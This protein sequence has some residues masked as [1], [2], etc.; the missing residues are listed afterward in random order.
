[1]KKVVLIS[2]PFTLYAGIKGH[3]GLSAPLNLGY[4]TSYVMTK[5]D[6]FDVE[7]YDAEALAHPYEM[8]IQRLKEMKP[9]V[10]GFTTTTPSMDIIFKLTRM[11]HEELPGVKTILGGPHSTALPQETLSE[12]SVDFVVIGEGEQTFLELLTA[13]DDGATDFTKIDGVA[14]ID[15]S[16]QYV[17]NAPRQLIADIETIPWP[18]RERMPMHL[19][20]SPPT[21][22]LG[23][24]NVVT[25]LSS[26]GCP[27]TCNY[28]IS[29]VMW[30]RGSVRYA[31][32]ESVLAEMQ[33]CIDHYNARE[34]NFHDDLFMAKKQ[35]L[36]DICEGIIERRK[37]DPRWDIG[38]VV[39]SRIELIDEP[40]VKLMKEAG[41][42]K[43]AFGIESGSRRMLQKMNKSLRMEKVSVAF[44]ICR[45]YHIKTGASFM[46]GYLEETEESIHETI[47]LMKQLTPDTVA[48]FQAS[49]YPGTEF[50]AEAKA[51]GYIRKDMRWEDFALVT[52]SRAVVDLPNLSADQ[53]RYWVKRAYREFYI[54]PKYVWSQM[55]QIRT[56]GDIVNLARGMG[57]LFRVSQAK[58][59]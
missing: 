40:R 17:R 3:G 9:M 35:R 22:S 59:Y 58:Q 48:I 52:N 13:I 7:I 5:S 46:I 53:I 50:Y 14:Y 15:A 27:F 6:R 44:D 56:W 36:F 16:G 32:A 34:F 29:G 25:M 41:C 31:P 37:T 42:E 26:R 43:I 28:C 21:K 20:Y 8:V 47:G 12:S 49:P 1:M 19:Y 33:Y 51:K 45:K 23:I 39:M 11:I 10:V 55:R 57:I 2:P 54:R 30:G 38:W 24:G 4:L 18:A